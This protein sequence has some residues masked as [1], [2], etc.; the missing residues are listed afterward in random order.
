MEFL[1]R[2]EEYFAK[3]RGNRWRSNKEVLDESFK[4][5]ADNW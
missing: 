2:V 4:E 5:L 1:A 3:H